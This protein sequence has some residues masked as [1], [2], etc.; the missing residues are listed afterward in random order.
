MS[1]LD[2]ILS[3]INEEAQ[4]SAGELIAEAQKTV[5]EIEEK[6]RTDEALS[7]R[8]FLERVE[9][10]CK[11][12]EERAASEDRQSRKQALL[13][14]R[15]DAIE[16]TISKAKQKVENLPDESY[17]E[18]LFKIF[19]QNARQAEGKMVFAEKD[20]ARLPDDFIKKCNDF[21]ENG[22]IKDG[23]S[24]NEIENGFII[25]YGKIE[26][27]C[28]IESIFFANKNLLWDKV[29]AYLMQEA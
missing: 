27:N 8:Q 23:G 14:T 18:F 13:K 24:T 26:Q 9:M 4:K 7:E 1:G 21:L 19:M 3:A 12:I 29:N 2:K 6:S 16:R 20:Y 5:D 11:Q 10:E 28:S 25:V 22:S 17:F 15:S